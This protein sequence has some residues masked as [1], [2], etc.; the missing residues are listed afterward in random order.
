[1]PDINSIG[2]FTFISLSRPVCGPKRRLLYET[3]MGVPGYGKWFD[4]VRGELFQVESFVDAVSVAAAH[5]LLRA[6][7]AS[8]GSTRV[9]VIWASTPS[10]FVTIH[11]VMPLQINATISGVG[12]LSVPSRAIIS[13]RWQL[14][15]E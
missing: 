12:G 15:S 7:E 10:G 13:C 14:L 6:Y 11:N 8:V 3:S 9:P 2:N 4:A 5:L 1:M